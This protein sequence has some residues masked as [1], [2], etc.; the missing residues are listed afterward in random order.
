MKI[1]NL[2]MEDML[3]TMV[4]TS[5]GAKCEVPFN[6]T[7]LS[8]AM[9]SPGSF[10]LDNSVWRKSLRPWTLVGVWKFSQLMKNV[11]GLKLSFQFST[12][13]SSRS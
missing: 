1:S 12:H 3:K 5:D 13:F 9:T 6:V 7:W 10:K 8:S 4:G 11:L 2:A